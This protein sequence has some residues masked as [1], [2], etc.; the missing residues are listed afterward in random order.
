MILLST[1]GPCYVYSPH[2]RKISSQ[3]A[4]VDA[5]KRVAMGLGSIPHSTRMSSIAADGLLPLEAER[6]PW[7][8]S[9]G[10]RACSYW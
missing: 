5:V 2:R 9:G 8:V 6:K 4:G 10:D 3:A 1:A 7:P